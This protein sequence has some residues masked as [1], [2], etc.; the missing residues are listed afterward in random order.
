M[1]SVPTACHAVA[2]AYNLPILVV[3]FNNRSWNAVKLGTRYVHP[4][5]WAARTDN[6]PLSS[7]PVTGEYE[8]FC[9]AYG[10]YGEKVESPD[11]LEPALRRALHVV[12]HEK[13]QALVNVICK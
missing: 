5:G 1:F 2:A 7:L 13:R 6:F 9:E 4:D 10:G 11:K 8:K 3:V 12:T